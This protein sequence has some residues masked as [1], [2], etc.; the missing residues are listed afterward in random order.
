MKTQY[1]VN[2]EAARKLFE[3]STASKFEGEVSILARRW[4]DSYGN[5]YHHV[6]IDVLFPGESTYTSLTSTLVPQYGYEQQYDVTAQHMW[7][8][9]LAVGSGLEG[10]EAYGS[11][12][13]SCKIAFATSPYLST[14]LGK[15]GII[16]DSTAVD[17]KRKKDM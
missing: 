16:C 3:M 6:Y 1:L 7:F 15:M 10:D 2:K 4:V 5:T 13:C 12:S 14:Y 17:V 9:A 8:N 11:A